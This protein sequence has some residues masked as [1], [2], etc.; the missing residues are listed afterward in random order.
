MRCCGHARST[1]IVQQ[2]VEA[3]D[4]GLVAVYLPGSVVIHST[5]LASFS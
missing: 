4:P 5:D 2:T 1:S 3:K